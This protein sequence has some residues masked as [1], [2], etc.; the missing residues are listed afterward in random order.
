MLN[1]RGSVSDFGC[2]GRRVP[3]SKP[4]RISA[5]PNARFWELILRNLLI[6]LY[7]PVDDGF[8]VPSSMLRTISRLLR[9]FVLYFAAAAWSICAPAQPLRIS[10]WYWLN[11]APRE[12]W[13]RDFRNMAK[14]GFTHAGL[15][16]G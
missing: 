6:R 2:A 9:G 1:A 3:A 13:D 10:A 11:S 12:E 8:N 5:P 7:C 15:C 14:L 16:W 4:S